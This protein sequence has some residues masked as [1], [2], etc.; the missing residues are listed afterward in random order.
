MKKNKRKTM[1]MMINW[2]VNVKRDGWSWQFSDDINILEK[3]FNFKIYRFFFIHGLKGY[4]SILEIRSDGLFCLP[5][6]LLKIDGTWNFTTVFILQLQK[7]N[8]TKGPG[9]ILPNC[10][11][12][13]ITNQ[14]GFTLLLE[15][16]I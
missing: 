9:A 1:M 14:K 11:T 10:T 8:K 4:K 2:T 15:Y 6:I 7:Q 5:S 3:N 16:Q 12:I 13:V